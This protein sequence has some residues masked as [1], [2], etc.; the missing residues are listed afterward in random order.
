MSQVL[1]VKLRKETSNNVADTTLSPLLFII[2]MDVLLN[3]RDVSLM[4]L[5]Y[6]DDFALFRE[7]LNEIIRK[8]KKWMRVFEGGV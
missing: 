6:A 5:L 4:E 3:V 1:S 2:V 8:Y 7:S